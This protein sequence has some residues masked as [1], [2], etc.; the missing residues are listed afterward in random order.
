MRSK[1]RGWRC[2]RTV[3]TYRIA[4]LSKSDSCSCA[5]SSKNDGRNGS[6]VV[7]FDEVGSI[8]ANTSIVG[9]DRR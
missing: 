4:G 9:P 8:F 5:I 7:L 1:Y 3:R 2:A 6:A